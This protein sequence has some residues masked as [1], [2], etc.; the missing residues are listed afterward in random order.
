MDLHRLTVLIAA[1]LAI[2]AVLAL[3]GYGLARTE[4][5]T[6]IDGL[7][8][9][10]RQVFTAH[11]ESKSVESARRRAVAEQIRRDARKVELQE[12]SDMKKKLIGGRW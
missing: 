11:D 6:Q 12:P 2:V 9:K 5:D 8:K 10:P 7:I 4:R 1:A 3:V